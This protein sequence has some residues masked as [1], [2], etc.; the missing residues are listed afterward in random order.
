MA[1]EHTVVDDSDKVYESNI[2]SCIKLIIFG[3]NI[4]NI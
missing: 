4:K 2:T 1:D 3:Y